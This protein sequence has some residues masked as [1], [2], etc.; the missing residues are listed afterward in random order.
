MISER[1]SKVGREFKQT[2]A[3]RDPVRV[4]SPGAKPAAVLMPLWDDGKDIQVIFTKRSAALPHHA[5]QISFPGGMRD[6]EDKDTSF[7]ALRE[8]AEEIGVPPA[9]VEIVARL[10]QTVTITDFVITPY[11]G[12]LDF[13]GDFELNPT[14]VDRLVIT[15]LSKVLDF[16][17]Y[18]P[19]EIKW[20]GMAFQQKALE[21]NG[22][23]IWGAT[24]RILL[25]LL[26]ALGDDAKKIVFAALN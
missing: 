4:D 13:N 23:I 15:P 1:L 20:Q 8:T 5:G 21:H 22:D 19:R 2:L 12:I 16:S 14:E 6:P 3:M 11:V 9:R 18:K 10:D 26:S 24:A 25:D 7:T 17:L